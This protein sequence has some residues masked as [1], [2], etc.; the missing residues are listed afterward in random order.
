MPIPSLPLSVNARFSWLRIPLKTSSAFVHYCILFV[1]VVWIWPLSLSVCWLKLSSS[2]SPVST[3]S[4]SMASLEAPLLALGTS[5]YAVCRHGHDHRGWCGYA[6]KTGDIEFPHKFNWRMWICSAHEPRGHAGIDLFV[7]QVYTG[8]QYDRVFQMVYAETLQCTARWARMFAWFNCYGDANEYITDGDFGLYDLLEGHQ[9]IIFNSMNSMEQVRL[10]TCTTYL[11][12]L[13][14]DDKGRTLQ[15]RMARRLECVT[16]FPALFAVSD[17]HDD[18]GLYADGTSMH[19]G[20]E[21]RQYVRVHRGAVY[22]LIKKSEYP[23]WY[24]VCRGLKT[25][26]TEG[27]WCPP[28]AFVP[29]SIEPAIGHEVSLPVCTARSELYVPEASEPSDLYGTVLQVF[30]DGSAQPELEG[31]IGQGIAAGWL[32]GHANATGR[33]SISG[34]FAGAEIAELLGIICVLQYLWNKWRVDGEVL[35]N[36]IVIRIDSKNAIQHVFRRERPVYEEG[37]YLLPAISLAM[38]LVKRFSD[39]G[40]RV[41]PEHVSSKHNSAHAIAKNEQARRRR[42][43]QWSA[44]YDVWPEFLPVVWQ[45]VFRN[46]SVN[47]VAKKCIYDEIDVDVLMSIRV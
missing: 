11:F 18:G 27:G 34:V 47:Q 37:R 8:G 25:L 12:P 39:A 28:T 46:V 23:V 16:E 15:D 17:W 45:N 4:V 32:A 7:G 38:Y 43:D 10:G 2:D 20:A 42:I 5:K 26:L 44:A 19:W 35:Y 22:Y 40:V 14:V 6:H 31:E 3:H 41:T 21:S 24:Y 33:A 1:F 13:A 36:V 29:S 9:E 30:T